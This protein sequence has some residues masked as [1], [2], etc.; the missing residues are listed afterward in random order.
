MSRYIKAGIILCLIFTL[1]I[2][3]QTDI[4]SEETLQALANISPVI[5][6]PAE[7][8]DTPENDPNVKTYTLIP[9]DTSLPTVDSISDGI[10]GRDSFS[11][12]AWLAFDLSDIPKNAQ[13]LS[14]SLSIYLRD[15][16]GI[17]TQR[18]LWYDA[19][20]TWIDV[21]QPELSDPGNYVEPD[22]LV[23][24]I[25]HDEQSYT[26]K[27]ILI[28][29]D[30]WANDIA[31][32]YISL[33]LTGPASGFEAGSAALTFDK[34]Q[35]IPRFPEL[36][37]TVLEVPQSKVYTN[38]FDL[39]SEEIVKINGYDIDVGTYSVPSFADWNNDGR[40]DLIVGTGSGYVQVYLNV[41]TDSE[42][43]FSNSGARSFYAQTDSGDLYCT[44]S[45]CMGCFPRVVYWNDDD[46]KDLLIG[47]SNGQIKIFLNTNTDE[48]PIFDEGTL[49]GFDRGFYVEIVDV[50]SRA[51][52][53][54]VDWNNDGLK[55]LICGALDGK[56]RIFLNEGTDTEP[57]FYTFSY[58]RDV[59]QVSLSVPSG[60]S[61]PV[62]LDLN[63]DG[64]KD[65][66]TGNTDGQLL[67]Y[68]NHGT[69][70]DPVFAEYQPV[71]ANGIVIDL[72]GTPRSRPSVCYWDSDGYPDVLI[73][74]YDGKIH[75][76]R[77]NRVPADL[78]FDGDID[79]T[80]WALFAAFWHKTDAEGCGGADLNND[81]KVDIGDAA[82][83]AANWLLN[84]K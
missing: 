69:D 34:S 50:G 26:L 21:N 15:Y 76:Y 46:K 5:Q 8:N 7:P 54:F 35:G 48:A 60:R 9:V 31:D 16:D 13:V 3:A 6:A 12:E 82:W 67:L 84:I 45:G 49:F 52:P 53:S 28:T 56:I 4:P 39:R 72:E 18:T 64:K 59:N 36:N 20:D 37:L 62:V 58:A 11:E 66:L 44:P 83:I 29:Y 74:A 61:S 38:L 81:G 40:T 42:P 30:G 80:D 10:G 71:D 14:A 75:L 19:A 78:D 25:E 47:Q 63:F 68:I 27:T 17:P 23:G 33:M 24:T 2:S 1:S 51:T 22:Q 73:G 79:F 65:I 55:D 32:G 57:A 70:E 41:G 77:C 43:Q